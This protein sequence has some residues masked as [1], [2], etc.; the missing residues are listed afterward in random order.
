MVKSSTV[1]LAVAVLT[2]GL[3]EPGC[4]V[5]DK[6]SRLSRLFGGGRGNK[7]TE[8]EPIEAPLSAEERAEA[9]RLQARLNKDKEFKQKL[10]KATKEGIWIEEQLKELGIDKLGRLRSDDIMSPDEVYE[11]LGKLKQADK[12]DLERIFDLDAQS[13]YLLREGINCPAW[14]RLDSFVIQYSRVEYEPNLSNYVT[15]CLQRYLNECGLEKLFEEVVAFANLNGPKP[16]NSDKYS[17]LFSYLTGEF[18]QK[19]KEEI[20]DRS[21]EL[22]WVVSLVNNIWQMGDKFDKQVPEVGIGNLMSDL[23]KSRINYPDL[24]TLVNAYFAK[25]LKLYKL[26]DSFKE[27]CNANGIEISGGNSNSLNYYLMGEFW[28]QVNA[29]SGNKLEADRIEIF[30]K[31]LFFALSIVRFDSQSP[32]DESKCLDK[33]YTDLLGHYNLHADDEH[34]SKLQKCIENSFSSHLETCKNY[35]N[36]MAEEFKSNN[37]EEWRFLDQYFC[38][39]EK[40]LMDFSLSYDHNSKQRGLKSAESMI[41][42]YGTW[43]SERYGLKIDNYEQVTNSCE[44]FY[45]KLRPSA[46]ILEYNTAF[47]A[48]DSVIKDTLIS[49]CLHLSIAV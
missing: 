35:F 29:N 10:E 36:K 48:E 27:K 1:L 23:I 25:Y 17:T 22:N 38:I 7:S 34:Y 20:D 41:E 13:L 18:W 28:Q 39:V 6:K 42:D 8:K 5:S 16:W 47:V 37:A 44:A 9:R 33:S 4:G 30:K 31:E 46:Y 15:D 45:N 43:D 49:H 11:L 32:F 21:G 19:L 2:I 12:G 26:E 3:A 24:Y 14:D 40:H